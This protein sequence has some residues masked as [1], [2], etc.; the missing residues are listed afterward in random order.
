MK[1]FLM[2]FAELVVFFLVAVLLSW[3]AVPLFS[4]W[5][6]PPPLLGSLF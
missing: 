6:A 4:D 3:L 2:A 1:K 5:A